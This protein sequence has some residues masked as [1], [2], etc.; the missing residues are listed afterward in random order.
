[1]FE[2]KRMQIVREALSGVKV[3]EWPGNM[4]STP[5]PSEIGFETIVTK[6]GNE[7][8]S[9]RFLPT[10]WREIVRREPV[11]AACSNHPLVEARREVCERQW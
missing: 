2:K 6:K 5:K 10:V 3:A 7:I 8:P 11:G 1:V 4:K 9:N